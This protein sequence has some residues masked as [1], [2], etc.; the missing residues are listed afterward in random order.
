MERHHAYGAEVVL[1]GE[2]PQGRVCLEDHNSPYLSMA[3]SRSMGDTVY[4]S[5]GVIPQPEI[6]INLPFQPGSVLLLA[7]DGL[8]DMVPIPEAAP[9]AASMASSA[10]QTAESLVATSCERWVAEKRGL[11][12]QLYR[13][14]V[15]VVVASLCPETQ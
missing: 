5:K 14:D 2:P 9:I 15:T 4:A 7:T 13:D 10:Q 6:V 11:G 3:L 8:Y 1:I 12:N